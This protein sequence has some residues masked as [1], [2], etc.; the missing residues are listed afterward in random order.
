MFWHGQKLIVLRLG[1]KKSRIT[2]RES[3]KWKKFM[4]KKY[5]SKETGKKCRAKELKTNML[6]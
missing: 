6:H 2:T 4:K 3:D 1:I 5:I